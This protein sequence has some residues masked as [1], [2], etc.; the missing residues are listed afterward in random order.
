MKPLFKI[1]GMQITVLHLAA[2]GVVGYLLLKPKAA[3][4]AVPRPGMVTTTATPASVAVAVLPSVITAV[5]DFLFPS[6]YTDTSANV[7]APEGWT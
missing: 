3:V 2:A 5:S 7:V 6:H 4:A 1:G